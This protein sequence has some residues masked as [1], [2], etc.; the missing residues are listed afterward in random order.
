MDA[1]SQVLLSFVTAWREVL[2]YTLLLA[3]VCTRPVLKPLIAGT[4][5]R[6]RALAVALLVLLIAGH[7]VRRNDVLYPC[8]AWKMYSSRE[9][10]PLEY[11]AVYGEQANGGR[12]ELNIGR[13]SPFGVR[14]FLQRLRAL[15]LERQ[16]AL[17]A[18]LSDQAERVGGQIQAIL[19]TL[20]GR[21]NART[22]GPPV[23][24]VLLE[25]HKIGEA[26]A[27]TPHPLLQVDLQARPEPNL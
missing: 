10:F 21:Y 26:F 18:G 4:S 23:V 16:K 14:E 27:I 15:A 13:L 3:Y 22:D 19:T 6:G 11:T 25:R 8:I 9:P 12:V 5:R 1:L 20:G 7:V 17:E 24:R 2:I